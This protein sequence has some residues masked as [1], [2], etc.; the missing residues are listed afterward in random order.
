[1]KTKDTGEFIRYGNL[2][3][4]IH[5]IPKNP[6]DRSY[7]TAPVEKGF[8][9]FPRGFIETFLLGGSGS[10]SLQNGRFRKLRDSN[11]NPIKIAQDDL[12]DFID[13]GL[14][15]EMTKE[16]IETNISKF[17]N[18]FLLSLL[19]DEGHKGLSQN[20]VQSLIIRFKNRNNKKD[21]PSPII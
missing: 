16:I 12:K 8:Y 11:G 6:E 5:K 1:M 10:G 9:A 13:N 14:I 17:I 15:D 19:D 7:H 4:Q 18:H 21:L 20:N 2:S 3:P